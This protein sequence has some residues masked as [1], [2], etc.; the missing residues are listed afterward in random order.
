M[1]KSQYVLEMIDGPHDHERV[2]VTFPS[3]FYVFPRSDGGRDK[4]E[5]IGFHSETLLDEIPS[6][7]YR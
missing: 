2:S 3:L 4:Y 7:F 6:L 1:G 5:R